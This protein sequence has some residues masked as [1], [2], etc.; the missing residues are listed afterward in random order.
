[1]DTAGKAVLFSGRRPCSISLSA[2]MLVPSPAFRSM[3]LG[4][5]VSVAFVLPRR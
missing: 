1:M 5:M 4:I 3:A 2:V